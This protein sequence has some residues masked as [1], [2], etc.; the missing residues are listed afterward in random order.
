MG[1]R[2][3]RTDEDMAD[4]IK[5]MGGLKLPL[6]VSWVKG[7]DRS[8]EQNRTMWMWA[9]EVADQLQDREAADVQAQWKLTIGIPI[10]RGDVAAFCEA[11]DKTVKGL[12]Y[13]DKI[14]V[15]R[16]LEFPVTR[17]MK[18]RQMCRF[19]N[20]IQRQCAEAGLQLTAPPDDLDRYHKRY[21]GKGAA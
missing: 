5:L 4:F 10:L 16:D 18:V 7:A 13:E 17:L 9:N 20:E 1:T 15:M 14:K 11:Y 3:I 6:T 8:D 21:S 2:I 12:S 19:M